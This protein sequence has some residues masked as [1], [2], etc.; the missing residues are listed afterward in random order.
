MKK[1]LFTCVLGVTLFFSSC[2]KDQKVVKDLE[3]TWTVSS[4]KTGGT[5]QINAARTMSMT[6]ENCKVKKG[7]CGGSAVI[8][9]ATVPSTSSFTYNIQ[10]KGTI[11]N[12]DF[13]DDNIDDVVGGTVVEHSDTKVKYTYTVNT[14]TN[15]FE[16]TK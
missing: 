10:E 12:I 15:E 11:I 2:S 3:G 1:I 16:L 8:T 4:W 14:V 5:E 13:A 7:D 9:T 6:F